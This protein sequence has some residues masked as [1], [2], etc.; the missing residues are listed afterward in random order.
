MAF[1][2]MLWEYTLITL[3]KITQNLRIRA[4]FKQ[5][6]TELDTR[7]FLYNEAV[8]CESGAYKLA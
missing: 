5:N 3:S 2:V 8:A 6:L 1:F 4:S 7:I